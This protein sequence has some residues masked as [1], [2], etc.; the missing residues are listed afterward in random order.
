MLNPKRTKFKKLQKGRIKKNL[1]YKSN[2][3]KFGHYGIKALEKGYITA[4]QIEA[5]RRTITNTMKRSG[6]VWIRIFP[7]IPITKKPIEV[8]MG[9]GKG[10]VHSWICKVQGGKV[11]F[12][13]SGNNSYL[14]I[15][16]LHKA[17]NKLPISTKLIIMK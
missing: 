11:L 12:E 1:N 7:A 5:T 6:K 15:K 8:R 3:L 16:A 9:K 17:I 10:N 13:V 4:K 2:E 14:I